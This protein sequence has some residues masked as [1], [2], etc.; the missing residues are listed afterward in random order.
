[1]TSVII[2]LFPWWPATRRKRRR[3]RAGS[4]SDLV[5]S[6]GGPPYVG[7][8]FCGSLDG[9][10]RSLDHGTPSACARTVDRKTRKFQAPAPLNR[11]GAEGCD[12]LFHSSVQPDLTRVSDPIPASDLTFVLPFMR[13][14][15]AF[16]VDSAASQRVRRRTVD[17]RRGAVSAGFASLEFVATDRP[18]ARN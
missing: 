14:A 2:N 1:M 8:P 18:T 16:D 4:L 12:G 15:K 6:H 10:D 17:T 5:P 13:G 11:T 7:P 9:L 3:N